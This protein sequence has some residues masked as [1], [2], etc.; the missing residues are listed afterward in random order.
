M[1]GFSKKQSVETTKQQIVVWQLS[2]PNQTPFNL[3]QKLQRVKQPVDSTEQQV[4]FQ[5]VGKILDFKK[6]LIYISFRFNKGM[7]H[8]LFYPDPTQTQ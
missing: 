1:L 2:Q 8:T 4:V 3:F 7:D 5:L 6:V